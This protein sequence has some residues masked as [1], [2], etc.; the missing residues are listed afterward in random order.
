MVVVEP[1]VSV[2]VGSRHVLQ[3]VSVVVV[4]VVMVLGK[5]DLLI[6]VCVLN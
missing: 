2:G 3:L 5:G 4:M 6:G 1:H